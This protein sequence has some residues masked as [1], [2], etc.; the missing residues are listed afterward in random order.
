[1]ILTP[2]INASV[3]E[4][5]NE[6]EENGEEIDENNEE[7]KIRSGRRRRGERVEKEGEKNGEI[8]EA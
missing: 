1:M 4:A 8:K 3:V 6:V 5:N 2:N 7:C